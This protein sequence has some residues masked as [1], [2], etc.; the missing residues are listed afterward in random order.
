MQRTLGA[1]I[2]S[3]VIGCG[4]NN[5]RLIAGI[6]DGQQPALGEP[7]SR[8]KVRWDHTVYSPRA[9]CGLELRSKQM[10]CRNPSIW[11]QADRQQPAPLTHTPMPR[12]V[13]GSRQMQPKP[14][15]RCATC[16]SGQGG[17]RQRAQATCWPGRLPAGQQPADS[18]LRMRPPGHASPHDSR[19]PLQPPS[20]H[21]GIQARQLQ[22][23]LIRHSEHWD[24]PAPQM[25]VAAQLHPGRPLLGRHLRR[26][27]PVE[28]HAEPGV[29]GMM[30]WLRVGCC[31]RSS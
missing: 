18:N 1:G 7:G 26:H 4:R 10:W 21:Q 16:G 29:G 15:M 27:Q 23:L 9:G 20:T 6:V 25:P 3:A 30:G 5:C 11:W 14:K 19:H 13:S 28:V 17:R 31:V 24:E 22:Q 8:T 12:T 2:F